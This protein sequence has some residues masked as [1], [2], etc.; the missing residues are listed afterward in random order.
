MTPTG[1]PAWASRSLGFSRPTAA[2][3]SRPHVAA[4]LECPDA[5]TNPWIRH[6]VRGRSVMA[7]A[8]PADVHGAQQSDAPIAHRRTGRFEVAP[9][10][11]IERAPGHPRWALMER[12]AAPRRRPPT[13]RPVA[14]DRQEHLA[15]ARSK[16]RATTAQLAVG[17][18]SAG[19]G[20]AGRGPSGRVGAARRDRA[21]AGFEPGAPAPNCMP[22]R[23]AAGDQA[24]EEGS[25]TAPVKPAKARPAG[26]QQPGIRAQRHLHEQHGELR[27]DEGRGDRRGPLDA[28]SP[29]VL[30][31]STQSA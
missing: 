1:L 31:R 2:P 26:P 7:V 15:N 21:G 5:G 18:G 20:P 11:G 28:I 29:L 24:R 10:P 3:G 19:P 25:M 6:T 12:R 8:G 22:G 27:V 30:A 9:S 23:R 16:G 17:L 14:L 4:L 13:P